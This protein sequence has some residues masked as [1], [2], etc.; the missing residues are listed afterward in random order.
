MAFVSVLTGIMFGLAPAITSTRRSLIK[1]LHGAGRSIAK[2]ARIH[3]GFVVAQVALT[4]ILLCGPGL[5]VRSFAALS[6]VPTG[7]DFEP[8]PDDANHHASG[9]LRPQPAS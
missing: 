6:S 3:Q 9:A 1:H 4:V 5:L 8:G 2:S 7:V